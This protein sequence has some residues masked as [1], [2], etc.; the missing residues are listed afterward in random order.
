MQR[1]YYLTPG[2]HRSLVDMLRWWQ[3]HKNPLTKHRRRRIGFGEGTNIRIFE[4]QSAAT[5]DGV[6]NCYEEMLDKTDWIDTGGE[7]RFYDK[8]AVS[9]EV[10]NLL[11]HDVEA[12]YARALAIGD[13][14]ESY[15]FTDDEGTSRWVGIPIS[16]GSPVRRAKTTAAAGATT[17]IVCNLIGNNG[18]EITSGLGSGITVY[19]D[20]E[21]SANLNSV[22]P[23]L[24]NDEEITVYNL[25]GKWYCSWGFSKWSFCS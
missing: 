18:V 1:G 21:D 15:Q 9:V 6:Y 25:N 12:T 22:K 4:V 7:D 11:E 23:R 10:L 20:T 17:T 16:G 13:R 5:G 24:I 19:C 8:N 14:I 3:H 2:F